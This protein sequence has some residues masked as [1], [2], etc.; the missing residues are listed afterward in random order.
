MPYTILLR[1]RLT[2]CDA[3]FLRVQTVI[4][5]WQ[6]EKQRPNEEDLTLTLRTAHSAPLMSDYSIYTLMTVLTPNDSINT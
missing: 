6:R 1:V 2:G 3:Y 4:H 5:I